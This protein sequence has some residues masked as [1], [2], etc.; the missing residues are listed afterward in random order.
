MKV[1]KTTA[2]IAQDECLYVTESD[3]INS[4]ITDCIDLIDHDC[5]SGSSSLRDDIIDWFRN[6]PKE[7]K[8][9]LA[10]IKHAKKDDE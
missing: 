7:V 3:A 9:V 5:G 6:H 2:F 1:T 4:N 10:N 8:Y